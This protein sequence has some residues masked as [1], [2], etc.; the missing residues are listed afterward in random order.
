[1]SLEQQAHEGRDDVVHQGIDYR[2]ESGADDNA[3]GHVQHVAVH[4]E[5]TK[6]LQK[7]FHFFS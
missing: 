2:L 5:F 1:L 4:G 7:F 3:D 6:F